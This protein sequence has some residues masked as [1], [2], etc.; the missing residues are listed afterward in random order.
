MDTTADWNALVAERDA[1]RAEVERMRAALQSIVDH[2]DRDREKFV[3]AFVMYG[4]RAVM[5]L[6]NIA[7]AA[8]DAAS[9]R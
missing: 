4:P 7:V 5:P 3:K 1:L 6:Y 8:L 9:R 2:F